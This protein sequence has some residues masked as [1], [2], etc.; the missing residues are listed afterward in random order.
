M[1]LNYPTNDYRPDNY[2]RE[3]LLEKDTARTSYYN[4]AGKCLVSFDTTTNIAILKLPPGNEIN[5]GTIRAGLHRNDYR[6][7]EFTQI[8]ATTKNFKIEATDKNIMDYVET[9]TCAF[10]GS[11]YAFII[12]QK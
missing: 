6:T 3:Q 10:G 11:K 9:P 12:K 2:F 5:L 8:T 7:W 4:F 1:K